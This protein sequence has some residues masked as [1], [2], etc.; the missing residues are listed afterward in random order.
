MSS[1][2]K[3]ESLPAEATATEANLEL[4]SSNPPR[5]TPV[6]S[7]SLTVGVDAAA[8]ETASQILQVITRYSLKRST[9]T[10]AKADEGV[11]KYLAVIYSYVK[12]GASIPM[13]LPGFPFKSPN[14]QEKVLGK[15]P[16]R[17]EELSLAHLNSICLSIKDIYPPGANLTIISDGLT[18]NDLLGVSDKDVWKYGETLRAIATAKGHKHIIFSRL[19]DLVT[20]TLPEELDEMTYVANASN[21][22]RALLNGFGSPD[23]TWETASQREDV[24]LTYKGYIK[25]LGIDLQHMYDFKDDESGTRFRQGVEHIAQQML[26]RGDAF[27]NAIGQKYKD[28]V[29]LSIH[30]STGA[31]KLSINLLPTESSYTTPWHCAVAYKLDGTTTTGRRADFDKDD[32]YELV[33]ENERPSYYREKSPLLSWGTEKG[34]VV[35][36]PIYPTGWFVRPANGPWSMSL[37]DVDVEK[38]RSLCEINSPVILRGFVKKPNKEEFSKKAE[39]FGKP[40]EVELW[41]PLGSQRPGIRYTRPKQCSLFRTDAFPLR[42][43]LQDR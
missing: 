33:Y 24:Q 10:T 23:W 26:A 18:Y 30:A 25:A 14:S 29:R 7:V 4:A 19:Q 15:L 3:L 20:I 1:T 36:E 28:Y 17:A 34:G 37:D 21:F 43:R 38:V 9:D 31:A 41:Y 13:A 22:R 12:A 6:P 39:E 35:F 32:S 8:F 2:E 11:M 5:P 40:P 42:W 16:D 27:A